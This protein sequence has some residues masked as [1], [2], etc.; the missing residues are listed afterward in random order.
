VFAAWAS[1]QFE[2]GADRKIILAPGITSFLKF[3]AQTGAVSET[4]PVYDP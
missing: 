4:A 1:A 2:L 3:M